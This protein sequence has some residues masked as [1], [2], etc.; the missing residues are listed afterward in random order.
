LFEEVR[1]GGIW[2]LPTGCEFSVG[3]EFVWE[4][5]QAWIFDERIRIG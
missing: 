2:S 5:R 3:A 4:P 1:Q